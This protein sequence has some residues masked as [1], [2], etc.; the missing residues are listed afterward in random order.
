MTLFLES[1]FLLTLKLFS[2]WVW[3]SAPLTEALKRQRQVGLLSLRPTWWDIFFFS[4]GAEDDEITSSY[5]ICT[6]GHLWISAII[7]LLDVFTL[8]SLPSCLNLARQ[9]FIPVSCS[10]FAAA[11]LRSFFFSSFFF[12]FSFFVRCFPSSARN[13]RYEHQYPSMSP[14]SVII[15]ILYKLLLFSVLA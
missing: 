8:T 5:T 15:I 10:S 1:V 4:V 13:Y 6:W 2:P 11:K 14:K 7:L 3:R 9:S 12:L